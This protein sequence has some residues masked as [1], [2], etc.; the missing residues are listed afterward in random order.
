MKNEELHSSENVSTQANG[1]SAVNHRETPGG[2]EGI[3]TI[4]THG[5]VLE[6]ELYWVLT[7]TPT[8]S[9]SSFASPAIFVHTYFL[10]L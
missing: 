3:W 8:D 6:R 2:I 1:E 9:L 10:Q 4:A 7:A 5:K